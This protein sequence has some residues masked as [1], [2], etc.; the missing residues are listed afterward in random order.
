MAYLFIW[1]S[2]V[3]RHGS[4]ALTFTA[5]RSIPP[6]S[7]RHMKYVYLWKFLCKQTRTAVNLHFCDRVFEK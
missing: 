5:G 7:H 6:V 2:L 1:V 3:D 4:N